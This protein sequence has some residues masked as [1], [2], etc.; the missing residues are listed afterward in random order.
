M[1]SI[2][3]SEKKVVHEFQVAVEAIRDDLKGANKDEIEVIKDRITRIET[4]VGLAIA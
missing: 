3:S 4:H 1:E 2:A